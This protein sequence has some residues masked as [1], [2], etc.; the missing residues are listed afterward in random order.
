MDAIYDAIE[1]LS[2]GFD[3]TAI[4]DRLNTLLSRLTVDRAG[5]LDDIQ[6]LADLATPA[7]PAAD[8]ICDELDY[9][10]SSTAE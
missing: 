7:T 10:L 4:I 5:Y 3:L 1:D 8:S 6:Y 2:D 9:L